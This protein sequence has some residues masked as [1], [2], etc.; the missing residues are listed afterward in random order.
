MKDTTTYRLDE[1]TMKVAER[2]GMSKTA[3][4]AAINATFDAIRETVIAGHKLTIVDFGTFDTSHR[5]ERAGVNP[6]T[7]ER[8][9]IP[10][11]RTVNFTASRTWSARLG[12]AGTAK[13]PPTARARE[14][15]GAGTRQRTP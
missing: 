1:L 11:H 7:R 2:T 6:Q 5:R 8:I 4:R 13:K 3:A 12:G 10:A 14:V 15:G 9:T